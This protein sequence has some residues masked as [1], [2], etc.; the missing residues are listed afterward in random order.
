[1]HIQE[2][3]SSGRGAVKELRAMEIY[4]NKKIVT[5]YVC[6]CSSTMLTT[7]IITEL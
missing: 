2:R 7:K 4:K 6:F 3:R 5:N 1:M